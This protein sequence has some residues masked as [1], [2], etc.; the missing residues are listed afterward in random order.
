MSRSS[1]SNEWIRQFSKQMFEFSNTV[2]QNTKVPDYITPIVQAQLQ[3][4]SSV[5]HILRLQS[6]MDLFFEGIRVQG[7]ILA[8]VSRVLGTQLLELRQQIEISVGPALIGI[9]KSIEQL[10]D[11]VQTALMTLGNHGWYLDEEMTV[12][13]L[14][15]LAEALDNGNVTEAEAALMDHF[16]ERLA[17]IEDELNAKFPVRSG[18]ISAAFRAHN[19]GEYDLSI[20]V[21]L[22]QTD[23]ICFETINAYLFIGKNS[24]PQT[25]RYVDT[26]ASNTLRF[27]MLYPL[28][29]RMP[30]SAS[31]HER[32]EYFDGLNRHQV[33][34]G[35]VLNYGTEINSLKAI[36]LL[37]YVSQVLI[38]ENGEKVDQS[39]EHT[40][41]NEE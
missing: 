28:S 31:E 17:S 22:A 18:V 21:L 36:S 35:E 32:N 40:E 5:D 9:F 38:K 34:H 10:P 7:E 12:P 13:F 19:R 30:I 29:Q 23:G 25:A 33:L 20:P 27:A 24:R 11:R 14:W 37:N 41:P 1:Y 8:G 26:L 3:Y 6:Q 4:R 15:E 16:R 2:I 39:G